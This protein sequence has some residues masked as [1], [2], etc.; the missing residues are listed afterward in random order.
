[1]ILWEN[2][3]K[4]RFIA[5]FEP[6][7]WPAFAIITAWNPASQP[8]SERRNLRRE[9]AL[10]RQLEGKILAGPLW[11]A[12]PDEQWQESS[13]VVALALEQACELAARFDQNALYWVEE[14][15]LWLVPVL[16]EHT[17]ICLGNI[18]S[19][20]IVRTPIR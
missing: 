15:K 7:H 13:L 20:W 14:G 12:S 18:E 10:W 9:R 6:P 4:I 5:P 19:Y 16:I 2:Y 8:V 17:A 11:G 3:K 1:M